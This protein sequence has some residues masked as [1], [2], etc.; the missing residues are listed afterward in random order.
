VCWS[1]P[2]AARSLSGPAGSA[3]PP[4]VVEPGDLLAANSYLAG[5]AVLLPLPL[6]PP[7]GNPAPVARDPAFSPAGAGSRSARLPWPR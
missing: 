6:R 7:P 4:R 2:S 3:L 5:V 1:V